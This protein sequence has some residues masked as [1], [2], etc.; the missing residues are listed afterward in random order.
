MAKHPS[1]KSW[2]SPLTILPLQRRAVIIIAAGLL[3]VAFTAAVYFMGLDDPSGNPLPPEA[4]GNTPVPAVA[5][6]PD[7]PTPV[8]AAIPPSTP[9]QPE[10]KAGALD[11]PGQM[12]SLR[13]EGLMADANL[14][15]L[16]GL[17]PFEIVMG[18]AVR[19]PGG[20]EL[21]ASGDVNLVALYAAETFSEIALNPSN[22][23]PANGAPTIGD[24]SR[25]LYCS[26][27]EGAMAGSLP[28]SSDIVTVE[29]TIWTRYPIIGGVIV[30]Y[31]PGRP[32]GFYSHEYALLVDRR[33]GLGLMSEPV[34]APQATPTPAVTVVTPALPVE[35]D[36]NA[37]TTPA[38]LRLHHLPTG[39]FAFPLDR[40]PTGIGLSAFIR[41]DP[42]TIVMSGTTP[43]SVPIGSPG[44]PPTAS[45]LQEASHLLIGNLAELVP[46][47]MECVV[48]VGSTA[49][50]ASLTTICPMLVNDWLD[51]SNS[52][53]LLDEGAIFE[54]E[55]TV[56]TRGDYAGLVMMF[57][58]PDAPG[59][60]HRTDYYAQVV[61][62][63][64]LQAAGIL[65]PMTSVDLSDQEVANVDAPGGR[66]RVAYAIYDPNT[67]YVVL[68][69]TESVWVQNPSGLQL[70]S[71]GNAPLVLHNYR[72][73]DTRLRFGAATS[74]GGA[75]I[76]T[77][78]SGL[79]LADDT[80]V[81]DREDNEA[82]YRFKAVEVRGP[83]HQVT[84]P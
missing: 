71:E 28:S 14:S 18:G 50:D 25:T 39:F 23:V 46:E 53:V 10:P 40:S 1:N 77:K 20:A 51:P 34:L 67:G 82:S 26:I 83:I 70:R 43:L 35:T 48:R 55:T 3:V 56:W 47:G 84:A 27:G 33:V 61:D 78:V 65:P 19:Q 37:T 29:I 12:G 17:Q 13:T 8:P 7:S 62:A 74:K 49:G 38:R 36:P 16:L 54:V 45:E 41:P 58:L 80:W 79:L 2:R 52:S 6:V 72:A 81:R 57:S 5:A 4:S 66:P 30:L 42:L 31:P 63:L 64:A 73:G 24:A 76:H 21:L 69:F 32:S 11:L 75:A 68:V 60:V 22:C 9:L 15:G 59:I 44:I